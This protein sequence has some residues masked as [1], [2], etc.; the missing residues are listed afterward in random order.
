MR[1]KLVE[2]SGRTLDA[3][4]N[5]ILDEH[6]NGAYQ[7]T[8]PGMLSGETQEGE[9]TLTT[10]PGT[11]DY[12]YPDHVNFPYRKAPILD[13]G[14]G[15]KRILG[16][17][18]YPELFWR[19]YER[20]LGQQSIPQAILFYGRVAYLRPVPDQAYTIHIFGKVSNET[21]IVDP[22]GIADR[23]YAMT[24]V[25]QAVIEHA[26]LTGNDELAA[27]GERVNARHFSNVQTR[28]IGRGRGPR[29]RITF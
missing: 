24:V 3:S 20:T 9:W 23:D 12:P 29:G 8:V 6:L 25:A 14:V 1:D 27:Q 4:N 19:R 18:T 28:S 13:V 5:T 2:L 15:G 7:W 22:T 10:V 11:G 16:Y 26:G 17:S 21:A